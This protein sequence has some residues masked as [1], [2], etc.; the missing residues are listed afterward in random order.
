ATDLPS[1]RELARFL[2]ERGLPQRRACRL[3]GLSRSSYQYQSRPDR[4]ASLKE[5]LRRISQRHPRWGDRKVW[6][7]LVREGEKVNRK[8]VQ[9]LW[10]EGRPQVAPR[11][12]KRKRRRGIV[13][14]PAVERPTRS[15]RWTSSL[16]QRP[17]EESSS[18]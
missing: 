14:R 13:C 4:N 18:G 2:I 6:A 10:R 5:K 3:S 11:K 12:R 15:G 7:A 17:P 8:R 1:Q 9:R 16:I